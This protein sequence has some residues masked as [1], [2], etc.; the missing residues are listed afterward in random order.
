[1]TSLKSETKRRNESLNI[2]YQI[3]QNNLNSKHGAI[4]QLLEFLT[5]Y[6]STGLGCDINIPYPELNKT[7]M[8]NLN[9]EKGKECTIYLRDN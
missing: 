1:M 7:I 9:G 6:V 3:K 8:G 2:I 5:V 4:R